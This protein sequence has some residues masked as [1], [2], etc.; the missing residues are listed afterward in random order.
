MEKEPQ[1]G[2]LCSGGKLKI[3]PHFSVCW[4]C[5]DRDGRR[6]FKEGNTVSTRFSVVGVGTDQPFYVAMHLSKWDVFSYMHGGSP[7]YCRAAGRGA[8]QCVS[9][10]MSPALKV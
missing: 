1:T 9:S 4:I 6:D 5:N 7:T 10:I 8:G 3:T 2:D